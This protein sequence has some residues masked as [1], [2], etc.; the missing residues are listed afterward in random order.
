MTEDDKLRLISG[1]LAILLIVVSILSITQ[2]IKIKKLEDTN[3]LLHRRVQ[4]LQ[5]K[6]G[7]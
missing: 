3:E 2:T 7:D 4:Q 5:D 1:C 6:N